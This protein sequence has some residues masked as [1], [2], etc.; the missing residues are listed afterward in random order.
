[1]KYAQTRSRRSLF[2]L[3]LLAAVMG[4]GSL[5]TQAAAN[6][7]PPYDASKFRSVLD[8]AKLQYPNSN[9]AIRQ[10]DMEDSAVRDR[11]YLRGS[12]MTFVSSGDDKRCEVRLEYEFRPNRGTN[13]LYGRV[14]PK[15]PTSSSM[16][17]FT[18]MQMHE[19]RGDG[20]CCRVVWLRERDGKSSHIWA[21]IR[22]RPGDRPDY[23]DLGPRQS[24]FQDFEMKTNRGNL[25]VQY[26]SRSI[27][28]SV[29]GYNNRNMYWKAGAYN[30]DSGTSKTE[31]SQ[32]RFSR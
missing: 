30:Q 19:Y 21:I 4:T 26:G 14:R 10:G 11:F 22:D 12:I 13:R 29:S 18:F 5:A 20:P 23:F 7:T 6:D 24:R 28:T 32:L 9:T 2:V 16:D 27:T 8:A 3:T 1:M 31:Y 17:Q 25:T 15:V